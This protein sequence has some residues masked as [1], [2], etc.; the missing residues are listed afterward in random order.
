[1]K[2]AV[3]ITINNDSF[4]LKSIYEMQNEQTKEKSKSN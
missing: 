1:M 2:N 4:F 3:N